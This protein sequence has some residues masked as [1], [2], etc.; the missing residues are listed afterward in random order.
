MRD[1]AEELHTISNNKTI[2]KLNPE[3]RLNL[4]DILKY[5]K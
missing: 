4:L 1:I 5:G 3:V 2:E